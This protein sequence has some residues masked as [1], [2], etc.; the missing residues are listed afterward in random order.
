MK[1]KILNKFDVK[2]VLLMFLAIIPIIISIFCYYNSVRDEFS[3]VFYWPLLG[4][5]L[6]LS[7]FISIFAISDFSSAIAN[8]NKIVEYILLFVLTALRC[9]YYYCFGLMP[10]VT[11]SIDMFVLAIFSNI[12]TWLNKRNNVT[13]LY[14]YSICCSICGCEYDDTEGGCPNCAE[15]KKYENK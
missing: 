13:P 6:I 4:F 8:H 15:M 1:N 7:P 14:E 10:A 5:C 12:A 2:V 11:L 3:G 9:F